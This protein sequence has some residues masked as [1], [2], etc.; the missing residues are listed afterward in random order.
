MATGG[1]RHTKG[2]NV[3]DL[4]KALRALH[5][6]GQIS[7]LTPE[8]E[9][10][11]SERVLVSGWYPLGEFLDILHHVHQAMGGTDRAAQEMGA[12]GAQSALEGVHKIFLRQGDPVGTVKALERIWPGHFDFG[13]L[14]VE[15]QAGRMRVVLTGYPDIAR[16]HGQLLVG[17]VR[18]AVELAGGDPDAVELEEAPWL[19]H[20]RFVLGMQL[21]G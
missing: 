15:E 20:G 16:V 8:V 5:K 14:E 21:D 6:A 3:V 12:F 11:L 17:W 7:G 4:V 2:V 19:G 18:R 9:K 13:A 1:S 10:Y